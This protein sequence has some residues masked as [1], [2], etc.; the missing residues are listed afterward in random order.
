[1]KEKMISHY[2]NMERIV[3]ISALINP[4]NPQSGTV[5]HVFSPGESFVPESVYNQIKDTDLYKEL[6]DLGDIEAPEIHDEV[7]IVGKPED[8]NF[9]AH[10]I[11]Q[12]NSK[13]L[14]KKIRGHGRN[15]G[16]IDVELLYRLKKIE[17]R[18]TVLQAIN[19]KLKELGVPVDVN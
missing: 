7:A 5:K 6:V 12:L 15:E 14:I 4:D 16:I 19:A 1:M 9:T 3:T 18:N 11:Q 17:D 13:T 2:S 10:A 8:K